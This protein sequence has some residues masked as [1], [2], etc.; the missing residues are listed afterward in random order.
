MIEIVYAVVVFLIALGSAILI[1]RGNRSFLFLRDQKVNSVDCPFVSIIVAARNEERGIEKAVRSLLSQE[2]PNYELIVVNDRSEDQTG[3][4]LE[5]IQSKH[6]NLK[7]ITINHLPK[8]W[9]GKNH[10]LWMGAKQAKSDLLLFTDGDV[11]MEKFTLS[12]AVA[13][14]E[15]HELDHLTVMPQMISRGVLLRAIVSYF[16][17]VLSLYLQPWNARKEKSK[18]F[19]GIGAFNLV[20][21]LIYKK[22]GTHQRLA[23]RPDDDLML[24]KLI[25]QTGARQDVLFGHGAIFVEWYSSVREMV[26]G[27]EKNCFSGVNYSFVLAISAALFSFLAH[28]LPYM[29]WPFLS[30]WGQFFTLLS[31]MIFLLASLDNARFNR[32]GW[33]PSILFPVSAFFFLGIFLNAVAKTLIRR[34]IKWRG[35]FYALSDLRKNRV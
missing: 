30:G 3:K 16:S 35:T 20:R 29:I 1:W 34:G 31:A 2:Y 4:I 5:S 32:L 24:G 26:L 27:L 21:K 17:F 19:V 15:H 25:K 6:G 18:R 28:V 13:F 33:F 12:Q 14:F 7:I 11:I 23:F 10:A 9:L 8:G 22:V